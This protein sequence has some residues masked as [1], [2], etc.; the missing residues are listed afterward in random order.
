MEIIP[1]INAKLED[2]IIKQ[3]LN[4]SDLKQKL[5]SEVEILFLE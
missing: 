3:Y 4:S 2:E 1:Q 5:E